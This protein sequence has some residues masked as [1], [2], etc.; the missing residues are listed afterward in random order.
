MHTDYKCGKNGNFYTVR[1][2]KA[3]GL[4]NYLWLKQK[5]EEKEEEAKVELLLRAR[6]E[7]RPGESWAG[8][9]RQGI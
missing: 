4:S 5:E 7:T 8:D 3:P 6:V 1:P 9:W 2:S